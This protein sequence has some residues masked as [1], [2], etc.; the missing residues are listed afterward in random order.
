MTLCSPTP[1]CWGAIFDDMTGTYKEVVEQS[2]DCFLCVGTYLNH[3]GSLWHS[4]AFNL[5][6]AFNLPLF[7]V[8]CPPPLLCGQE[9]K[10]VVLLATQQ[11]GRMTKNEI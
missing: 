1:S 9:A 10:T 11:Q 3:G 6:L 5:A 7:A 4:S 8:Q 2:L